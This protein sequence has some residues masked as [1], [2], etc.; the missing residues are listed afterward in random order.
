MSARH[1][2]AVGPGA[3][4]RARAPI[5]PAVAPGRSHC[6]LGV[7]FGRHGATGPSLGV[8]REPVPAHSG[9]L[10]GQMNA[11]CSAR[12]IA[13]LFVLDPGSK[14]APWVRN[15]HGACIR[16]AR[17]ARAP[18]AAAPTPTRLPLG[19]P[20]ARERAKRRTPS[21]NARGRS[22]LARCVAPA[23]RTRRGSAAAAANAGADIRKM[24]SRSP[25]RSRLGPG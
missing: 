12:A 1:R 19:H 6:T 13:A 20:T 15:E 21:L 17:A 16:A 3:R 24:T 25:L 2:L 5:S 10:R 8:T 9:A 22:R 4:G 14:R 11:R 18:R 23:S 7:H